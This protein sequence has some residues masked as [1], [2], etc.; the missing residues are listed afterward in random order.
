M[1]QSN[2]SRKIL[3][4]VGD[5]KLDTQ[6]AH[7]LLNE[8]EQFQSEPIAI[9]GM[10]LKFPNTNN[11]DELWDGLT[12]K[13]DYI[14][15]FPRERFDLVMNSN[16]KLRN[17]YSHIADDIEGDSRSY[18]SWLTDI[19][20]FDPDYFD[21]SE[22]EA[23]FMGPSERLFLQTAI[24]SLKRAGYGEEDLKGS[25][26]GVYVA[27]T[28]H[29][30]FDYLRLF[31]DVDERAFLSNI[32]ANLGYHLSYALDLRGPVMAV[33]TTCSSSLTAIHT[34]KNALRQG[35][36]DLA[37][38]SGVNLD[39]FPY[40]EKEA[41]DYVVRSNNYRCKPFDKDADGIIGGEGIAV[42]V[43]KRLSDAI[44][45]GNHIHS[46]IKGSSVSSD[47][48]S[49]GMQV[50]NPDA[51]SKA[52]VAALDEAGL[53]FDQINFVEAHGAGTQVGDLIEVEGLNKAYTKRA[54]KKKDCYLGSIKSN[55]GHMGD[56]AGISG[57]IKA[58]LSIEKRMIPGVNHFKEVNPKIDLNKTAFKV[59][60]DN[61]VISE[62]GILRAGVN[63]IGISGTN[64]HV[65]IEE[66]RD[67][68]LRQDIQVEQELPLLI[69]SKTRRAL[70][71]QLGVLSKHL[72]NN[73]HYAIGS[74]AYTLNNC[75]NH[76]KSRVCIFAK[77]I[78]D[79]IEKI[80]RVLHVRTFE[81]VPLNF[82]QQ[83]IFLADEEETQLESIRNLDHF[84][85]QEDSYTGL[86]KKYLDGDCVDDICK[87]LFTHQKIA[88]LPVSIF[89]TKRIWPAD[90]EVLQEQTKELFY[91]KKWIYHY[92]DSG[93]DNVNINGKWL[94]LMNENDPILLELKNILIENGAEVIEINKD[95][96]FRKKSSAQYGINI[97]SEDDFQHL[98]EDIG[99]DVLKELKGIVHG[100]TLKPF[101]K[102]MNDKEDIE[103][104]QE[105]GV[106]SLFNLTKILFRF[107]VTHPIQ[108]NTLSSL[109]EQVNENEEVIPARVTLFG[110]AKVI[111]QEQ[112]T[113]S[114][115]LIDHDLKGDP[116]EIAK[117]LVEELRT[118]KEVRPELIAYRTNQRYTKVIERQ[119][120]N[121]KA[122]P[123]TLRENGN[124]V[125]A[126]GTGYL[127]VQ[128]GSFLSEKNK[129]N[130]ILLAR[131]LLPNRSEWDEI[132]N[133][134]N[135]D[136]EMLIYK[137]KMIRSIE[138][139]GSKV[140]IM[141]CDVTDELA[142]KN[143]FTIIKNKYGDINGAFML[144]KQLYHLWIKELNIN[145][146]KKGIYN[147]V[148]ST[149]F[150]ERELDTNTLDFFIL[151]S[152]ISSL[153]GTKSA[154]ECCAVNQYLDSMAG[155]LNH[156]G[157]NGN[158]INLT[159]ILDDK[160]D[161]GND[162]AIPPIDFVEFQNAL[163]CFFQNGYQWSLVSKFDL[164]QVHYLKP[165]LKIPFGETFWKEVDDY[166]Y[167]KQ[168]VNMDVQREDES[169]QKELNKEEIELILYDIWDKV[170]GVVD[171][172]ESDNFFS[173]GGS[174]LSALRFVQLMNQ[175]FKGINF[176]VPDLYS[177]PTFENQISYC[178]RFYNGAEKDELDD[179]L[180]ALTNDDISSEEA[181]H[182][183]NRK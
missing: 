85:Q 125:I 105:E 69:S 180:E 5:E 173:S 126:G 150:I 103:L 40:W 18:G 140:N 177:N 168:K 132:I 13:Q 1:K 62:A 83:G 118:P 148:L 81:K 68:D 41:P 144:A 114:S 57:L 165:V 72:Q 10:S 95:N 17:K 35:D 179:I 25:N 149:H 60:A 71:E 183:L 56:A 171:V 98:F 26:T 146:F 97:Q 55:F 9:V 124:Y 141:K 34:A 87:E 63:S 127:G 84:L 117:Q 131:N 86:V 67:D 92:L 151:F 74:L 24:E 49:N 109:T 20:Q 138:Q 139:N 107:D 100:F 142:V 110:L 164:E 76:E 22:H 101:D 116:I 99:A 54:K 94:I 61:Q 59:S 36:C 155:Y 113:I 129:V 27:H 135:A 88:P 32:P 39:L 21:L 102:T 51:Q 79:L 15:K 120:E 53:T 178:D 157:I 160:K 19:E 47:G 45:E 158:T 43:V 30:A 93:R 134:N 29:P 42:V 4:L 143:T 7:D 169:I 182:L 159:L 37:V 153:M 91:E 80:G 6:I 2:I 123:I 167:D 78:E 162:T 48:M 175:N 58:A 156:K 133:R 90:K 12:E 28:P 3:S 122:N 108:I 11:V 64:V 152:S 137:I 163:K 128:L 106:F 181:L 75:R 44:R 145:Q 31:N 66:Y 170:L 161:F 38:V 65:V 136:D 50:P 77:G 115:F 52:I 121:I 73:K 33:N 166:H 70:W 130:I 112:P 154:S 111:S 46:V 176:E 119:R 104:T 89:N 23:K 16:K 174:S 14:T 82:Y 172:G 8:V 96:N 147:R